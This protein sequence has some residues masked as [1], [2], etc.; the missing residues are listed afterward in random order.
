M[1]GFFDKLK[2]SLDKGVTAA[3]IR[4]KELLETQQVKSR[5]GALQDQRR[6]ALEQLGGAV[7]EMMLSGNIDQEPLRARVE[8]IA[9]LEREI[10]E[11]EDELRQIHIRAEEALKGVSPAAPASA[12][13]SE[14]APTQAP[15]AAG[16]T[17]ANCGAQI[18]E[19]AKFCPS[20]GSKVE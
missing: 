11:K 4:S 10:A 18:S 1:P 15:P 12:Q 14:P 3:S 16:K 8:E 19:A 9:G 13:P 6:S 2:D 7:Y 17:C 5:I 20:C